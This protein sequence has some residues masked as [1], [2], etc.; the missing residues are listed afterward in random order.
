MNKIDKAF[1][2]SLS[3][4]LVGLVILVGAKYIIMGF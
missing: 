3:L 4:I 2:D 1:T